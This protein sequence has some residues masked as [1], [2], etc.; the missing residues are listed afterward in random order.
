M[1][2][3]LRPQVSP[4]GAGVAF[5]NESGGAAL[6]YGGL[7]AWD[8]DGKTVQA[9]FVEGSA[10]SQSITVVVDDAEAKYPITVDPIAQQASRWA[11]EAGNSRNGKP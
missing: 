8:A 2:G 3:G 4:E 7:R 10:S 6:T 11:V 5:L 9:R 1:C